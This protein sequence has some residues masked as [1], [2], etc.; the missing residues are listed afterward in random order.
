MLKTVIIRLTLIA[1]TLFPGD[2]QSV[3]ERN[4]GMKWIYNIKQSVKLTEVLNIIIYGTHVY[5]FDR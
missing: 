3:W 5:N 4:N 2:G 1:K